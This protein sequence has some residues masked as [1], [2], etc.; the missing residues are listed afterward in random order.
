MAYHGGYAL[1]LPSNFGKNE[2]KCK[3]VVARD[4]NPTPLGGSLVCKP[5][6]HRV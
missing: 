4:L 2:K 3:I 5:L 1:F 6:D